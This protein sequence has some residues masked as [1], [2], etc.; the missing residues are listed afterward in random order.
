M[1]RACSTDR[2][3]RFT[4]LW[5]PLQGLRPCGQAAEG[6]PGRIERRACSRAALFLF[7][8]ECDPHC[9]LGAVFGVLSVLEAP[10]P[11]RTPPSSWA[12]QN[13]DPWGARKDKRHPALGSKENSNPHTKGPQQRISDTEKDARNS[14]PTM[15]ASMMRTKQ[16]PPEKV[17]LDLQSS[18]PGVNGGQVL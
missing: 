3:R 2:C 5:R 11:I 18:V 8:I 1:Q 4:A 13:P 6:A 9:F 16:M 10:K 14:V 7:S 12:R 17:V 15:F